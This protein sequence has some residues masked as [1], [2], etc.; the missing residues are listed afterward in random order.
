MIC[1]MVIFIIGQVF[2]MFKLFIPT[3][4]FITIISLFINFVTIKYFI[5]RIIFDK[6]FNKIKYLLSNKLIYFLLFSTFVFIYNI[7]PS[8]KINIYYS[9]ILLEF[10]LIILSNMSCFKE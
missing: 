4:I 6:R 7:F 1:S 5:P 8:D 10:L 3:V 9:C 2:L